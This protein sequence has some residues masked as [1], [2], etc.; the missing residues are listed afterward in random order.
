MQAR[1]RNFLGQLS[2][3]LIPLIPFIMTSWNEF[4]YALTV[5]SSTAQKTTTVG[6][7]AELPGGYFLRRDP[8]GWSRL[9]LDPNRACLRRVD[10]LLRL[11]PHSGGDQVSA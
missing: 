2:T 3:L 10:G 8:D 11:W 4:I 1:V 9:G 6:V 5:I 7:T